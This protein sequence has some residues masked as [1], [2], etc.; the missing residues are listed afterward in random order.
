MAFLVEDLYSRTP[1]AP[2]VDRLEAIALARAMVAAPTEEDLAAVAAI[3]AETG[4]P[5]ADLGI[6]EIPGTDAF[7]ARE[8]A[9][10]PSAG[11]WTPSPSGS[12]SSRP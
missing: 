12:Q 3:E 4:R 6:I 5:Y 1:P 7:R 2:L 10:P 9:L 8:R 11:A